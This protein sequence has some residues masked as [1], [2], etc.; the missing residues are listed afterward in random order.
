MINPGK[1]REE[2]GKPI[3]PQHVYALAVRGWLP[4]WSQCRFG[5]SSSISSTTTTISSMVLLLPNRS[6]GAFA[7]TVQGS[8]RLGDCCPA[9]S[10]LNV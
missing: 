1:R 9:I 8:K 3:V 6:T 4:A 2:V 10:S 7:T 5:S